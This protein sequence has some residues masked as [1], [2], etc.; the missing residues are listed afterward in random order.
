M[1]W[2][3]ILI[4]L[5]SLAMIYGFVKLGTEEKIRSRELLNKEIMMALEK[6]VDVPLTQEKN[7][8]SYFRKGIIWTLIGL[9]VGVAFI[10]EGD[11]EA[12]G[13]LASVPLAVGIGYLSYYKV[14][15]QQN[16]KK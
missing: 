13:V 3:M 9:F 15:S 1:D 12:A 5:G 11:V 4:P 10:I 2:V 16:E 7:P 8:L 14:A 6:G